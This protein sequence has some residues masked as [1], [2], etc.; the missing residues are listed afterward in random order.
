MPEMRATNRP[1]PEPEPEDD[2]DEGEGEDDDEDDFDED[3]YLDLLPTATAVRLR[4]IPDVERRREAIQFAV[5]TILRA[6][7][8]RIDGKINPPKDTDSDDEAALKLLPDK[9]S[10]NIRKISDPEKRKEVVENV[11][12]TILKRHKEKLEGDKSA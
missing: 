5:L 11:I 7:K 6:N 3:E 2:R 1:A 8:I 4:R 9:V 12:K 10:V